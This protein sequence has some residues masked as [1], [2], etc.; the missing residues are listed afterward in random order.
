MKKVLIA[1]DYNPNSEKVMRQGHE[2][3]KL[4][5]AEVCLFHVLAEMRYYNMQY[6]PFMGFEGYAFPMDYKIQ[7]EYVNVAKEYLK[8]AAAHL[9]GENI[10]THLTEGDTAKEVLRYAKEWGADTI[11]MGTHSHSRLE[12]LFLGTVASTVLE[13][14]EIPVYMV[15]IG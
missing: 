11:V 12:K 8:K 5:N 13:K 3:A 9:G 6:E 14:T 2:L 15:P 10:S 1:I 7:E 4:M